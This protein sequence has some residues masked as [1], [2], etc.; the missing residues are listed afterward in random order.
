MLL[1]YDI[2][3]S[4]CQFIYTPGL[5]VQS[6]PLPAIGPEVPP[7]SPLEAGSVILQI[8][9]VVVVLN[10]Q[11]FLVDGEAFESTTFQSQDQVKSAFYEL[12]MIIIPID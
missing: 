5:H 4:S 3:P 9:E 7:S 2:T 12:M 11:N 1:K 8:R 6:H 10:I